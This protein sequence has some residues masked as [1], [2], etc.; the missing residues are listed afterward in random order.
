MLIDIFVTIIY[1]I[2]VSEES[3][4]RCTP[5]AIRTFLDAKILFG[6]GKAANA[7]VFLHQDWE[8]QKTQ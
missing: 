3:N 7:R 1:V 4:M 2:A 6:P 8:C 5:E